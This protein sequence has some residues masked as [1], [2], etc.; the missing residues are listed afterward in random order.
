MGPCRNYRGYVFLE[1]GLLLA[2]V[3]IVPIPDFSNVDPALLEEPGEEIDDGLYD[4]FDGFFE[5]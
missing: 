4:G 1:T 2:G 5:G 3:L